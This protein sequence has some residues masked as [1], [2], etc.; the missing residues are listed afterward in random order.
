MSHPL[1]RPGQNGAPHDDDEEEDQHAPQARS[2]IA[3][4][5]PAQGAS[6]QASLEDDESR[7]ENDVGRE[8]MP[9]ENGRRQG[10]RSNEHHLTAL[11][12]LSATGRTAPSVTRKIRF[13][14][15]PRATINSRIG[16]H[17]IHS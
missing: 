1:L 11:A 17:A 7:D 13:G 16:T 5:A 15:T 10:R 8:R 2:V 14:K 9:V 4:E 12:M 6:Q 3:C